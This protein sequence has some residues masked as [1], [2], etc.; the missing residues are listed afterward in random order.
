MRIDRRRLLVGGGV[1]LGLVVAWSLWPRAYPVTLV[2]GPGE[3]GF[4]AWLKIGEDGRVTVAVPQVEGGQGSATGLA[5][6]VADE[7]GADWRT[8]G[9]EPAPLN[10]LYANPLGREDLL[11]GM[12]A[13][14]PA[15]LRGGVGAAPAPMLTAASSSIR[16]FEGPAREAAATARALLCIAAASRWD[17]DWTACVAK[18]GF[19]E[20]A[21]KRLRFAELA[22]DAATRTP[23]DLPPI[24]L[25]GAGALMGQPLPRLDA[26]AKV[27]GS[28][29]FAGDI[30]L[31]D[32]VFVAVRQGPP[33]DTRLVSID[34]AA[35]ERVSGVV[36]VLEED[37]W[38]AAAARTWWSAHRALDA[39]RPRFATT[40]GALDTAAADAAML[41]GLDGDGQRIVA[42]GDL[43]EAFAGATLFAATYRA[44]LG[45]PA[46]IETPSAAASFDGERLSLWLPTEAPGIARAAAATAAGVPEA[47]VTVHP[48]P[49]GGGMGARIDPL[50]AA[51]AARVAV[52][53][54]R[55]VSLVWSRGEAMMHEPPRAPAVARLAAR[56][57]AGGVLLGWQTRIASPATGHGL[58]RLLGGGLERAGVALDATDRYAA[59]GAVP[60]YRVA[61][62][63]VDHHPVDVGL[64]TG[65]LRGGAHPVTCFFT[66][67]FVDE[68]AHAARAEPVSYRIGLLGGEP[69]LARC[70]S[71]VGSLGGWQGGV[72]GSGQGVACH[73]FRGSFVAVMAEAS[74]EAGRIRVE[75]LVAAID[76]GRV[77]NPDLVRQQVEGGLIF[78]LAHALGAST[79]VERGLPVARGFDRLWLPRLADTPDITVELVRSDEAP[80][81]VSELAVPPVAP[82]IANA[83]WTVTGT[84]MR[85]LPLR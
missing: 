60:P 77:V 34:R 19:V 21:G 7:L 58:V 42:V 33:G 30:R 51:Q 10:P 64:P 28:A 15:E 17:A 6:I 3:H 16:M 32:M 82:A 26:P 35:A 75:R 9:I 79:T 78:G 55:P 66:E 47:A 27:D 38:V 67:S 61:A 22:A 76:C 44:D 2:A 46:P 43:E 80:G 71:V 74:I 49:I 40:N 84:R 12:P 45:I 53:L 59:G 50:L 5:Q 36:A 81:G 14:L 70:L 13:N 29:A 24:G 65:H 57:G 18:A 73:A 69:R 11:E 23:P 48:M 63:A 83:L 39:A 20:H 37:G 72:P 52:A 56:L 41:V 54:K 31:P 68:L 4:G 8:V 85:R 62:L 1:G 25:A